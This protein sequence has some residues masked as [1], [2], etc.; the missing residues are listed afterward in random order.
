MRL[1]LTALSG[2]LGAVLLVVQV[3]LAPLP[4]IELVSLL[5]VLFTLALGRYVAYALAVF[6]LLEGLLYGFGLWW[7]SYLYIW[8]VLAVL[9]HLFRRMESRLGWALLCGFY[10]LFFGTLTAVPVFF[11]SGAATG[12][13]Y[14]VSGIPFDLTHA[15]GNFLLALLLL[16]P[17]RRLL[18]HL[19][20]ALRL[21]APVDL[22][23]SKK[24]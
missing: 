17:L 6:V 7:C 15:A 4:N 19:T 20:R 8:A 2:V 22:H 13:A 1:R 18:T 5:V 16:P 12:L 24:E 14:I 10:G 9:A 23:G 21:N 11:L 3:A